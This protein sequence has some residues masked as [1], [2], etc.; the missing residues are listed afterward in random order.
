[1]SGHDRRYGVLVHQLRVTIPPQQDAEVI[2][3]R[4][5][6]LQFD[7][8]D[9]ENREW[10]FAFADVIKKCVLKILCS[11]GCHRRQSIYFL[12]ATPSATRR[13]LQAAPARRVIDQ[14]AWGLCVSP[15]IRWHE[16]LRRKH[17][18]AAHLQK[19]PAIPAG[20]GRIL[21][22][23]TGLQVISA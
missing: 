17:N 1:M 23:I 10:R 9:Q 3:P 16:L 7:A 12:L 11:V 14:K 6:A 19:M 4:H 21:Y 22:R 5:D 20:L 2:E 18:F 8:V 15:R 13:C